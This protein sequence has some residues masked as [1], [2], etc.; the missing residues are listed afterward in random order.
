MSEMRRLLLVWLLCAMVGLAIGV[1]GLFADGF[2]VGGDNGGHYTGTT[3]GVDVLRVWQNGALQRTIKLA[4]GSSAAI[5]PVTSI[6][7]IGPYFDASIGGSVE[8]NAAGQVTT[9]HDLTGGNNAG[10]VSAL[11]PTPYL[12]PGANGHPS[13]YFSNSYT[14]GALSTNIL[15][16][17]RPNNLSNYT[18]FFLVS[19]P[20]VTIP[21]GQNVDFWN[22]SPPDSWNNQSLGGQY[23]FRY[24]YGGATYY[25]IFNQVAGYTMA[26]SGPHVARNETNFFFCIVTNGGGCAMFDALNYTNTFLTNGVPPTYVPPAGT[27]LSYLGGY[28]QTNGISTANDYF[29][30]NCMC[31]GYVSRPISSNEMVQI[32]TNIQ[33]RFGLPVQ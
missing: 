1:F 4:S 24:A 26:Y 16:Y 30:G 9:W 18:I 31:F 32:R 17:P 14:A 10:P 27:A 7:G 6:S 23:I 15:V 20:P 19:H 22:V 3:P 13:I 21:P 8:T 29:N 11:V 25:W 2:S 5:S 28:I 33:S 12:A